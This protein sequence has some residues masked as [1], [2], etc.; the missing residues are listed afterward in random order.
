MSI[1]WTHLWDVSMEWYNQGMSDM[2]FQ[3]PFDTRWISGY[4]FNPPSHDA[5]DFGT[6]NGAEYRAPQDGTVRVA[7][8][9]LA[10]NVTGQKYG[11]GNYIEIDHGDGWR[12]LA[13]HLMD[14]L[15]KAGDLVKMGQLIGHCDN[16]G[17]SSGPHCHFKITHNGTPVKPTSVLQ[18][19]VM[20]P[21][22]WKLPTFPALPQGVIIVDTLMV[23]KKPDKSA[24]TSRTS[25]KRNTAVLAYDSATD[26]A[27]NI[28]LCIGFEQW[29]CGYYQGQV[30][31]QFG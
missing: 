4:D 14:G 27:G 9:T 1:G 26:T 21:P 22:V 5:Q 19:V 12:T 25:L 29:I 15:V 17:W 2:L 6:P 30:Y 7:R 23:R 10:P 13:A 20:P 28:W 24:A 8:F 16:T 3:W 18:E 31:V 11:Y